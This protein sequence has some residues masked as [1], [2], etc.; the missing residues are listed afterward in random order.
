M[1]YVVGSRIK[2]I[3]A[4]GGTMVR[5]YNGAHHFKISNVTL[6]ANDRANTCLHLDTNGVATAQQVMMPEVRS[7]SFVGYRGTAFIVGNANTAVVDTGKFQTMAAHSLRWYGGG[8]TAD[9]ELVRGCSIN[10]QN[11]EIMSASEWYM[12]P[13]SANGYISHKNHIVIRVGACP[14]LI[15]HR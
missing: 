2:W 5:A 4:I 3:G 11:M 6:D 9:P 14:H 10:A 15:S 13:S 1:S 12:D 7:V 8:A